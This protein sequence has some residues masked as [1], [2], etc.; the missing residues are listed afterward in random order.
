M[1]VF[2][3]INS[4]ITLIIPTIIYSLTDLKLKPSLSESKKQHMLYQISQTRKYNYTSFLSFRELP[5][6][7]HV[8]AKYKI[9]T[10]YGDIG[11][12]IINDSCN[13]RSTNVN[14]NYQT[15][16]F[17]VL[18]DTGSSELWIPDTTCKT[19]LCKLHN[20]FQEDCT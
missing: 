13:L 18:F 19:D 2:I 1:N 10:Y 20:R 8:I 11:I 4:F 6:H 9:S 14:D 3:V 7:Q 17:K 16:L 5:L 12:G 15:Q